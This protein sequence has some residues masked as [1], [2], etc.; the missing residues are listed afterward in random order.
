[1]N[2]DYNIRAS[3]I[4]PFTGI[5]AYEERNRKIMSNGNPLKEAAESRF[6]LLSLY[7]S[8]FTLALG[9][10]AIIGLIVGLEKLLN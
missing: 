8:G 9:T 3:D 7:N 5:D 6:I 10:G 4:V 2:K 1:M